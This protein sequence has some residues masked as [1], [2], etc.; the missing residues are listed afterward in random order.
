MEI[1]SSQLVELAVLDVR[2]QDHRWVAD[3][4]LWD[5]ASVAADSVLFEEAA[6]GYLLFLEDALHPTALFHFLS[7]RLASRTGHQAQLE[8][9]LSS[10]ELNCIWVIFLYF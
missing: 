3:C 6:V 9:L 2:L 4:D 1:D 10:V 7:V 8:I 5:V